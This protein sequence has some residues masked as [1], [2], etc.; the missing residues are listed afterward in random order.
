M[1]VNLRLSPD[2]ILPAAAAS[3]VIA[4]VGRRGRGKTTT[5]VVLVEELHAAGE[6]FVVADPVGVWWGLKS[7]RD[8]KAKG[9][10][11][12][13]MGGEHGD[14]PLEETAGRLIADFVAN[15]DSPSVVLDFRLLRKAQM[16]RFMADFLEQLYHANH[17]TL[18]VVLDE[19]DQFAPQRVMGEV[20]RLVGAAEDV[21]K[22]GRARGLHPVLITQRPAALNKNVLT[23][24]GIL[25][26]HGL[27]GPQDKDAVEGW[28][29]ERGDEDL[30]AEVLSTL[31]GLDRGEAWV[32]APELG[33]LKRVQMRDRRTFDSSAT[34]KG[35]APKGP[36]VVAQVDLE[37]LK[38]QIAATIE[39]AKAEDPRELRKTI[40]ALRAELAAAAKAKP[41]PAAKPSKPVPML[42]DG[43]VARL[44]AV[45]RRFEKDAVRLEGVVAVARQTQ[46]EAAA[47]AHEI[48]AAIGAAT[49]PVT[50]GR[51]IAALIP[52]QVEGLLRRVPPDGLV[53]YVEPP[54]RRAARPVSDGAAAT[55]PKAQQRIL[56][57]LAW[58]HSVGF[59][60]IE[61]TRAALYADLTPDAGHTVSSFGALRTAGLI[62]YPTPG[63]V[64]LTED[65]RTR[66]N[67]GQVPQSSEEMQA[68][69]LAKLPKAQRQI[70][71]VLIHYY[72]GARPKPA[73]AEEAGLKPEAGHTVSQFGRL[74]SLGLIDYPSP[75]A[76]VATP[77]L[78]LDG[79]R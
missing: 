19:A 40:A 71:S 4:I 61:K 15:T 42:K 75:G 29:E 31:A 78:F 28:I 65:G 48:R 76:V 11:V 25:I 34:P 53:R 44:E 51:G 79:A 66:A 16:R 46:A 30:G 50:V 8:G 74:R 55:L 60:R 59:E 12:V 58:L 72:P 14:V 63:T 24:A 6:R 21:C 5:A 62:A 9:I 39:K 7:S 47:R 37:A 1:S 54:R 20:A 26:A 23:Q 32:W 45:A 77:V 67:P 18:H 73:I 57:A 52:D 13:V 22:M 36:R 49:A 38:K 70:L 35:D 69:V 64:A 2:F 17:G 3:D 68:Q 10:P 27:T 33:W 41:A 56:D 43:Q